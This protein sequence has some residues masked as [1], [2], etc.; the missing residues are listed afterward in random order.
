MA[1]TIDTLVED[2]YEIYASDSHE[3]NEKNIE[4]FGEAMKEILR[5]SI[6]NSKVE[7]DN[8]NL[9]MSGIGTPDRKAWFEKNTAQDKVQKLQPSTYI[10]FLYG[11][12]IEQLLVFFIKE[13]GHTI[14]HMQEEVEID[15]V[16]GHTDGVIDGVVSDIKTASGFQFRSK[17]VTGALLK[18]TPDADPFGY[19]AQ[20]SAYRAK[21]L[22]KYPD[23]V[24]SEYVAWPVFNK[25]TGEIY[26]LKADFNSL[27]DPYQRIEHLKKVVTS[28]TPP[29]AKCYP[30]KPD[31]KSGN[32]TLH[33]NCTYCKFKKDCWKDSNEGR[34]LR[35]FKYSNGTKY[36][37]QI[38]SLPRVEEITDEL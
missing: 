38:G 33:N 11:D 8:S 18:N 5:A 24:D 32:R 6:E 13:S 19:K 23:K 25:E 16:L 14:E 29:I 15:G 30:D 37:T 2:I 1:K 31:G 12:I 27:I 34:G 10:K 4:E 17:W 22:E 9:R 20:I 3:V 21:L 7:R 26:V 28:D 35:A 36:L